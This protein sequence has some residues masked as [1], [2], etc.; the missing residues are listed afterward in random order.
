MKLTRR[1][2]LKLSAGAGVAMALSPKLPAFARTAEILKRPIPSSGESVPVV[3]VGTAR[4]F[5][6]E[7]SDET[8]APLREVLK[9]FVD[10]GG[11]LLDTATGYRNSEMVS[12]VLAELAGVNEG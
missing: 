2:M 9:T 12:G 7:P 8:L 1:E 11:T 3:G 4:T 5:N 6:V 10:M